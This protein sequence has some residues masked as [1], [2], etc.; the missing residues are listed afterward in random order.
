MQTA[1]VTRI[2]EASSAP[3]NTDW[4]LA[5]TPKPGK[6]GGPGKLKMGIEGTGGGAGGGVTG[7]DLGDGGVSGGDGLK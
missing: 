4:A 3:P 6:G 2:P 7:G 1:I 5:T